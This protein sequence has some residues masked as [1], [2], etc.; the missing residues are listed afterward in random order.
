MSLGIHFPILLCQTDRKYLVWWNIFMTQK[1]FTGLHHTWGKRVNACMAER[2]GHFQHLIQHCFL[3]PYFSII[4]FLTN[5]TRVWNGL[6]DF[7][8]TLYLRICTFC[9]IQEI[10]NTVSNLKG[11]KSKWNFPGPMCI[12]IF[13]LLMVIQ[14]I[15]KIM[16]DDIESSCIL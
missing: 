2:G 16:K 12:C 4:Y 8:I 1:L 11:C 13:Y 9:T 10:C 14:H 6:R 3:F 7:S 5:T 15:L